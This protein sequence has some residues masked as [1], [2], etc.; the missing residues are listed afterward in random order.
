M[1]NAKIG[2]LTF[3]DTVNYGAVLQ[4]YALQEYIN[5]KGILCEVIDYRNEKIEKVER[6]IQLFKQRTL[7]GIIKYFA[8]HKHQINKWEKFDEFKKENIRISDKSYTKSDINKI[9]NEYEKIIVGSDQVWNTELT[10]NDY[11]YYLD[12]IKNRHK[13]N[14]YAASFGYSEFPE[15]VKLEAIK[16]LKEFNTL[17]VREEKAKELIKKELPEKEVNVS[18][19]PTFLIQKETWEKFVDKNEKSYI[20]VYMID[21]KKEVFDFIKTL[22]KQEGCEIIYIHDS[23]LSQSG[24]KNLKDASVNKFLSLI[25]NAKY[26]VTGSF[27]ALCMSLIFEKEFYFTLNSKNNRNSRLLNLIELSNLGDRQV[28]EGKCKTKEKINYE[29][30]NKKILPKIEESKE[31]LNKILE[32]E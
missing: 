6:P 14:S 20:V 10:G 13:K 5:Q 1:K 15:G 31:L 29:E 4:E 17:N 28:I 3:Q 23:I 32:E 7:K 26:V 24:M 22:A 11:T 27:H 30:V 2:I 21:F 16:N 8:C 12:F 19:D 18:I 25:H 9:E